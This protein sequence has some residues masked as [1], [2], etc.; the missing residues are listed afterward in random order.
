MSGDFF[1]GKSSAGLRQ[2]RLN[3]LEIRLIKVN[4]STLVYMASILQKKMAIV[5]F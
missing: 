5:G 2:G 3:R 4:D 1:A